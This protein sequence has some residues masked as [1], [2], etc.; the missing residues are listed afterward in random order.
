M[1]ETL[2][3]SNFLDA[4]FHLDHLEYSKLGGLVYL[5]TEQDSDLRGLHSI[6]HSLIINIR[7]VDNGLLHIHYGKI[8]SFFECILNVHRKFNVVICCA[9]GSFYAPVI[10]LIPIFMY[11]H[12]I[13]KCLDILFSFPTDI[14]ANFDLID[15][16]DDYMKLNGELRKKLKQRLISKMTRSLK[17]V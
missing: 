8:E 15:A 1:I 2:I 12:S 14:N 16:L 9:T 5:K 17:L 13:D 10:A 7:Q 4:Q 3:L 11:H 6:D